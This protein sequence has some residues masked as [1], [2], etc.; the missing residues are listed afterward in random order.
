M[1]LRLIV[2]T[3]IALSACFAGSPPRRSDFVSPGPVRTVT[4]EPGVLPSG[5]TLLIRTNDRV[6]TRKAARGTV[7][8]ASVA[9]DVVDQ[10]GSVLIPKASSVELEVRPLSYLGPG[11]GMSELTLGIRRITV[12]GVAYPVVTKTGTPDSDGHIADDDAPRVVGAEMPGQFVVTGRRINVPT[13]ALLS[14]HI[15]DPI[16]LGGYSR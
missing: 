2:L 8:N 5:T 7:Y 1:K 10:N 14:F 13:N 15:A 9:E 6:N 16:R 3:T 12:N 4:A 11:G